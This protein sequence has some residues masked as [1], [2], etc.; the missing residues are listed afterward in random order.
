MLELFTLMIGLG[1]EPAK[2]TSVPPMPYAQC[3][4]LMDS[5]GSALDIIAWEKE[6]QGGLTGWDFEVYCELVQQSE[7]ENVS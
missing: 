5:I 4:V 1:G 6:Q 3:E 2:P 7:V